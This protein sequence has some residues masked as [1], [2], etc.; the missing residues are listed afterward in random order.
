MSAIDFEPRFQR[1]RA[2]LAAEAD[3]ELRAE[4]LLNLASREERRGRADL[5][6]SIYSSLGDPA[7]PDYV[8]GVADRARRRSGALGGEGRFG[9]RF[10]VFTRNFFA[11]A[12]DPALLLGM[13]VAGGLGTALR[14]GA[15][16]R[17][18]ASP[19]AWWSRGLGA[20]A[21]ASTG[22]WL[23]EAPAFTV[24][25]RLGRRAL[26]SDHSTSLPWRDELLSGYLMLGALK[27]AGAAVGPLTSRLPS[28]TAGT[29]RLG[30]QLGALM[31]THR[32]E[33]GLGL[34]SSASADQILAE[35][36]GT[37]LHFHVSGR[38]SGALFG[39]GYAQALQGL[40]L[41]SR[42]LAV[43]SLPPRPLPWLG[44]P[45][46]AAAGP[47]IETAGPRSEAGARPPVLQ[48]S[49]LPKDGEAS[50]GP[51][52]PALGSGDF[53][54]QEVPNV[55]RMAVE[56]IVRQ[57]EPE[58]FEPELMESLLSRKRPWNEAYR[59]E[60]ER[61]LRQYLNEDGLPTYALQ[62]EKVQRYLGQVWRNSR[63]P[64]TPFSSEAQAALAEI[65]AARVFLRDFRFSDGTHF[66]PSPFLRSAGLSADLGRDFFFLSDIGR[67]TGSFKERGALVEVRKAALEG[68]LHVVTAS[69]GNHG[70][71]VALAARKLG[72]RSTVVVPDTT[73]QVKVERLRSLGATVVSTGEKPWRG[74]E[75]A[76]DWA[77]QYVLERNLH[78]RERLELDPVARYIHG[79]EDVIPGQG[80]AAYEILEALN[81]LPVAQRESL[82]R[83]TFLV[84]TGG[85]GLAAGLATVLKAE[86]PQARVIGVLSEEA[87]AMHLSLIDG[88]RSEVFLNAKS[89]CDSGIGLTIPGAR[90][91]R[92]LSELLDGSLP[93]SDA[94]V[95]EAM[96]RIYR[97]EGLKVEGGAATGLAAVLS[98]R[99]SEWGVA[100]EAP[101]VT[102]FTGG[103][104]DSSRHAD[105]MAGREA[106]LPSPPP[107]R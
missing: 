83:A 72:L 48:M 69:H 49:A 52:R 5:A 26:G 14:F 1:E 61:E 22:A 86:L 84:P 43:S 94:W 20:R 73:P 12:S 44:S 50:P 45:A 24:A 67:T 42:D 54:V 81:R 6:L 96:R 58:F 16:S 91:F 3:P 93:V 47:R 80:V 10:E 87:P 17:L 100:P 59:R 9:D 77:V 88:R 29:L 34:R 105:V 56:Q 7:S 53:S 27:L 68:V 98:G 92:L 63:E 85:G 79:F 2:A 37:L 101:I 66:A 39:P 8:A 57:V 33:I 21:L 78:L 99:L 75:E 71:A 76:R 32:A 31:L 95:G 23:L 102:V 46:Y 65:G 11:Q 30:S 103:N 4:G 13:G 104:I 60:V 55:P 41:R 62:H 70:L 25:T 35:S 82:S 89:L 15:L 74:Y 64:G 38:L 97:H 36:L 28:F 18:A 40:E 51:G 19:A 106:A 107:Q 90:A